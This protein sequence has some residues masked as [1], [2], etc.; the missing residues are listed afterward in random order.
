MTVTARCEE[1]WRID[2]LSLNLKRPPLWRYE[3]LWQ[4][5]HELE[6]PVDQR[7]IAFDF[8]FP[9]TCLPRS[10]PTRSRGGTRSRSRVPTRFSMQERA[11]AT[12]IGFELV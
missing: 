7:W 8:D 12:P 2:R 1:V 4:E 11:V 5:R 10:R 9:P 3:G 6:W